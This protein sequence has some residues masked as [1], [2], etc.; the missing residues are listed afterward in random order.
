MQIIGDW[1]KA[2]FVTA[3][4][5]P[6]KEFGCQLAPGND[7]H[8]II[9][10]D[11]MAFPMTKDTK[12]R[13]LLVQTVMDPTVQVAFNSTKGSIPARV[14]A[15]LPKLDAC[16]QIEQDIVSHTPQNL[17][18]GYSSVFTGDTEGAIGDFLLRFWTDSSI[19]PKAAAAEFAGIIGSAD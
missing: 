6:G 11:L 14:D 12:G 19:T 7:G 4:M 18:P 8:P 9:I 10:T 13:D 1:A 17:L 15:P 2:E 5:T 16:S 3:G